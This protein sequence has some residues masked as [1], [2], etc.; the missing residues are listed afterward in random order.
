LSVY[1]FIVVG[2]IHYQEGVIGFMVFNACFKKYNI[3]VK[4]WR[5]V[6]LV[7]ETG[8]PGKNH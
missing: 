1:I 2:E 5:S 8:G 7:E 6:L 4:S 3:S